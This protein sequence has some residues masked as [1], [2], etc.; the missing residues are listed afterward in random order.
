MCIEIIVY[1]FYR[2]RI[3]EGGTGLVYRLKVQIYRLNLRI[4]RVLICIQENI[5]CSEKAGAILK[6]LTF[7]SQKL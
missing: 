7:R 1:H 2:G 4:I 6:H 3:L 5:V